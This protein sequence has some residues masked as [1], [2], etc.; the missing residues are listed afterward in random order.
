MSNRVPSRELSLYEPDEIV[1][2]LN[3]QHDGF[4]RL[5]VKGPAITFERT[6]YEY[7]IL[8]SSVK[9]LRQQLVRELRRVAT[10]YAALAMRVQDSEPSDD[11]LDGNESFDAWNRDGVHVEALVETLR[12]GRCA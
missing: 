8:L 9:P 7:D 5:H 4:F 2:H 12:E 3:R 11:E 6:A 10:F 1:A